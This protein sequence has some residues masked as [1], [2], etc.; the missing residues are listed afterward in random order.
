MIC[1]DM[2]TQTEKNTHHKL[3]ILSSI[4][5]KHPVFPQLSKSFPVEVQQ[6]AETDRIV[7]NEKA[8]CGQKRQIEGTVTDT[9]NIPYQVITR[10]A[11]SGK[12]RVKCIQPLS[13]DS[14]AAFPGQ[15][16]PY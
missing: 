5:N 2:R 7:I 13:A 14:R 12:L 4:G 15:S 1:S 6:S 9:Y 16:G 11:N 3:D 10:G 8:G